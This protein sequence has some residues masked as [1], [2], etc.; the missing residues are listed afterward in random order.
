MTEE[1]LY[2]IEFDDFE[3]HEEPAIEEPETSTNCPLCMSE[4]LDFA[5]HY[6][7]SDDDEGGEE[8]H[9]RA[10]GSVGDAE[11]CASIGPFPAPA[12][13]GVKRETRPAAALTEVA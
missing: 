12:A 4:N 11:E 2:G 8:Y 10:C 3:L 7:V 1:E 13:I 9:C 5:Y 6:P